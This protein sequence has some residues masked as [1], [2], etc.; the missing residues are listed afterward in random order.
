MR[1]SF[2][3]I[4]SSLC[5]EMEEI[6]TPAKGNRFNFSYGGDGSYFADLVFMSNNFGGG[7]GLPGI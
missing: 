2:E 7:L 6:V 1:I 5:K 3:V 4:K